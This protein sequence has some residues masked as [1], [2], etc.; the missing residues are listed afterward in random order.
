MASLLLVVDADHDGHNNSDDDDNDDANEQTPPLLAAGTPC[1]LDGSTNLGVGLDDVLVNL[2]ALLFNILHQRFLLH[3][4]LVEVLEQLC[5]L[6]HLSL[7]LLNSLVSLLDIPQ[8]RRC[9]ATAVTEK[10]KRCQQ[11]FNAGY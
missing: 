2:L 8:G 4:D 11:A 6:H 7:N 3:N 5:K 10:L 1:F 9:L